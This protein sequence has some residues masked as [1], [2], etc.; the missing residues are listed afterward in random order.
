MPDFVKTPLRVLLVMAALYVT[1]R[2]LLPSAVFDT[3]GLSAL[4]STVWS[5]VAPFLAAL[6][7]YEA[8][9]VVSAVFDWR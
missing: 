3:L 7:G 6:G 5:T 9:V 4:E 2:F 8:A 1:A